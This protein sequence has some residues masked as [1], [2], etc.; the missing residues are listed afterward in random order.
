MNVF[1][2]TQNFPPRIGGIQSVIH[3]ISLGLKHHGHKVTVFPDHKASKTSF[4]SIIRVFSPKI[5]RPFFKK[6]LLYWKKDKPDLIIC[7]TWKSVKAVP[8]KF[9]NILVLAHGQEYLNFER[10]GKRIKKALGR[11][12]ILIASSQFTLSLIQKN[13]TINK[14]KSAVIYPTYHIKKIDYKNLHLK[15]SITNI[16]T[17]CRIEKRKGLK[18]SL[19]L[20]HEIYKLGYQFFW[21]IIGDGPQLKELI[22]LSKNLNLSS[23]VK[24]HGRENNQTVI[25]DFFLKADLFLMPSYQDKLSI[26]GF[27]LSYIEASRYSIPSIAGI[28][29]GASEAIINGKTGWCVDTK[30]SKKLRKI[31][32]EAITNGSLRRKFGSNAKKRFEIE[33]EGDISIQKFLN[34]ISE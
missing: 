20:L 30:D 11:S 21:N 14:I 5:F 19:L 6:S 23:F 31:L 22:S 18:E 24:F 29:G 27:G 16:F 4:F 1:I 9:K 7:D 2:V 34:I 15:N 25:N 10:N 28:D 33:L 32:I 17:I 8:L 3:S 12:Q 26:E 13:W